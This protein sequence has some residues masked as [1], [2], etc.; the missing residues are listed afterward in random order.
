MRVDG[1]R[2]VEAPFDGSVDGGLQADGPH[3]VRYSGRVIRRAAFIAVVLFIAACGQPG[4][5]QAHDL[6]LGAIYPLSGPQAPG[7]LEELTGV[8]AAL[9]VA[10]SSGALKTH[11]RLQVIDATTPAAASFSRSCWT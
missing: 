2:D 3:R 8:R 6:V 9:Q 11:V 7:G 10:E 1:S 4:S 5:P